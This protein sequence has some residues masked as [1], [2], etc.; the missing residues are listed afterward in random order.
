MTLRDDEPGS[1]RQR[2]FAELRHSVLKAGL[3]LVEG[4]LVAL[5]AVF[6]VVARLLRSA[7]DL[8][9]GVLRFLVNLVQI[10]I[11]ALQGHVGRFTNAAVGILIAVFQLAYSW[12]RSL[13]PRLKPADGVAV[14]ERPPPLED[15][16]DG[17]GYHHDAPNLPEDIKG[18]D[19]ARAKAIKAELRVDGEIRGP[20]GSAVECANQAAEIVDRA[21]QDGVLGH[22]AT[23]GRV[24]YPRSHLAYFGEVR[25]L[26]GDVIV[27]EAS[28]FGVLRDDTLTVHYSG[29]MRGDLPEG[30]GRQTSLDHRYDGTLRQGKRHGHGCLTQRGW[31]YAGEFQ[32]GE[33]T[34]YGHWKSSNPTAEWKEHWG[35]F[36]NGSANGYGVRLYRDGRTYLGL[37]ENGSPVAGRGGFS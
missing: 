28:G 22:L 10:F 16:F 34:G 4:L 12:I 30:F 6:Q 20:V 13:T 27:C 33:I 32:T 29:A 36:R 31:T 19:E 15:L 26:D 5:G 8:V 3:W 35:R 25:R 2:E 37:F 9:E 18:A 21:I 17:G 23:H 1:H 14:P 7:G 24:V 11:T